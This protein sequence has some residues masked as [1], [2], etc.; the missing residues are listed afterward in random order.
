M[1]TG[2][3]TDS[4]G[5][6]GPRDR[7]WR[8][9]LSS[10]AA[11]LFSAVTLSAQTRDDFEYWDAN[12]NGDLTCS[13][14]YRGGG[15]AGLKLPAYR[16]DRH[17][18]AITYEWL[19]RRRSS[20]GDGDGSACESNS[21][22]TG[23]VPQRVDTPGPAP[24]GCGDDAETWRGL[25]VCEER[26]RSGY[27]RSDYGTGYRTLEDEIIAMLPGTMKHAGQ[28]Y[29]PYSCLPFTIRPG[30][31]AGTDIEHIVALAEAHDSHIQSGRRRLFASDLDNL[32]IA[33]PRVNRA[34]KRDS[35]AGEWRPDHHGAWFAERVIAVKL[36]YGLSVDPAERDSLKALLAGGGARLDCSERSGSVISTEVE[37]TVLGVPGEPT[38]LEPNHPNP[39]NRG[40]RIVYQLG[41]AGPVRLEIHNALGQSVRILVDEDFQDAGMYQVEWDA[42]D[43]RRGRVASG[44][45]YSRLHHS[46][47][48]RTRRLLYLR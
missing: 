3:W 8:C 47:Q 28:V 7:L 18:T 32:T 21:N 1:H 9:W 45:Y 39:F 4:G 12:G 22:P 43:Q 38:G 30:G 13:E 31:G 26:P 36:K 14:A 46:G 35:D 24:D 34:L 25:K 41:T 40:T 20:D 15:P 17:G 11:L 33:D 10:S 48:A 2:R 16:Y 37:A 23:Y 42:R 19:Q 5:C 29:T 27:D 6:R 44:V